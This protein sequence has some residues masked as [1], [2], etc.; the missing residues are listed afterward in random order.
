LA[1]YNTNVTARSE[2][3]A[4]TSTSSAFVGE[5]DPNIPRPFS[6]LLVFKS[7]IPV[8]NYSI[9]VRVSAI[10]N[11]RPGVPIVNQKDAQIQIR[12]ATQQPGTTRQQGRGIVEMIIQ[13]LRYLYDM[14]VGSLTGILTPLQWS[15]ATQPYRLE[16]SSLRS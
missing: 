3:L 2:A 4:A 13:I 15:A 16:P 1:A 12:R 7:N 11:N 10:D 14:F 8:G 5:V 6:M 9:T